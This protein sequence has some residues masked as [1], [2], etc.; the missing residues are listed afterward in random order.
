MEIDIFGLYYSINFY[1]NHQNALFSPTFFKSLFTN[2]F[3]AKTRLHYTINGKWQTV[4]D[5]WW[6]ARKLHGHLNRKYERSV[7]KTKSHAPK[8][9]F[10]ARLLGID[11]ADRGQ[12]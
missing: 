4:F 1:E 10:D 5:S 12:V 2:S 9:G 7:A 6:R 8:H 11:R 3:S